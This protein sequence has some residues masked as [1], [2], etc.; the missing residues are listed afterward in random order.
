MKKLTISLLTFLMLLSGAITF[1]NADTT[2]STPIQPSGVMLQSTDNDN[3][4]AINIIKM[5][6][7]LYQSLHVLLI[8]LLKQGCTLFKQHV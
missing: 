7:I 8:I 5:C 3:S 4:Q 6:L 1:V 2:T